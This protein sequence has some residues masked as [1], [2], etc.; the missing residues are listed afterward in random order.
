MDSTPLQFARNFERLKSDITRVSSPENA[1]LELARFWQNLK[2]RLAHPAYTVYV[3]EYLQ[4][5]VS[6]LDENNL[7]DLTIEELDLFDSFLADLTAGEIPARFRGLV[8]LRQTAITQQYARKLLY[9]GDYRNA[10]AALK[11]EGGLGVAED[12]IDGKSESEIL[13]LL[14]GKA[15]ASGAHVTGF[16]RSI[17]SELGFVKDDLQQNRIN[18]LFAEKESDGNSTRGRLR[19]LD[20]NVE[21]FTKKMPSHE[22][23]FDNQIRTPKDPFVGVAY[24]ALDAVKTLFR[25]Q[26]EKSKAEAQYHA[27]FWIEDSRQHFTGDSIG[28]SFALLSYAQAV[29]SDITRHE[30]LIPADVAVT[31]S[32]DRTGRILSVNEDT[33]KYKV[34]R[35]FFSPVRYLVLPEENHPAAFKILKQLQGRFPHRQLRLIAVETLTDIIDD[36]NIIRAEKVCMGEYITRKTYRY[37]RSA[38]VQVPILAVLAYLLVCLIYPQIWVCFDRRIDHLEF[39]EQKIT[40]FNKSNQKLWSSEEF[41]LPFLSKAIL[42]EKAGRTYCLLNSDEDKELELVVVPPIAN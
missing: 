10:L 16:L 37:T 2:D 34:E 20:G 30:R 19:V 40:T 31:G 28:L 39:E 14:C 21:P 6:N 11:A 22:V 29:K 1:I 41:A 32:I 35:A 5:L 15:A 13:H 25:Y 17:L 12:K 3:E 26:G 42:P 4:M 23:T 24:E 36:R 9:V 8:I 7:G 33:L 27:H 38:K 18:C